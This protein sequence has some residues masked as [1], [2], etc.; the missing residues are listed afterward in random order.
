MLNQFF[1]IINLQST[2]QVIQVSNG[3]KKNG[4]GHHG[5]G[6]KKAD[7]STYSM[8]EPTKYDASKAPGTGKVSG[9]K[10][11]KSK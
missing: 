7:N 3:Y 8:S 2:K 11:R 10:K 5:S 1:G 4:F 6:E 9:R